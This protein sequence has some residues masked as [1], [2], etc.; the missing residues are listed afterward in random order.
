M[1]PVHFEFISPLK[2]S[3][4][5][6]K[7]T[8]GEKV[9]KKGHLGQA[10]LNRGV[11]LSSKGHVIYRYLLS[12]LDIVMLYPVATTNLKLA[13]I[14]K[15]SVFYWSVLMQLF[16]LINLSSY[17]SLNVC[18]KQSPFCTEFI[19]Y[20]SNS[21]HIFAS[22]IIYLIYLSTVVVQTFTLV[23]KPTRERNMENTTEA[24]YI[25]LQTSAA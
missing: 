20:Y 7:V 21:S 1:H 17:Q 8:K 23:P 5:F 3:T 4:K 11:L 12:C 19:Q 10:Q 15:F 2:M 14:Y 6:N 18:H 13:S 25:S 24:G 16:I 22:F 9:I